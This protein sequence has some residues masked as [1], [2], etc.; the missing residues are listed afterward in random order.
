MGK[1]ATYNVGYGNESNIKNRDNHTDNNYKWHSWSNNDNISYM[2][3]IW[4]KANIVGLFSPFPTLTQ[5]CYKIVKS[6][7]ENATWI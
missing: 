5:K 6:D 7:H 1:L 4:L 3:D 2:Q